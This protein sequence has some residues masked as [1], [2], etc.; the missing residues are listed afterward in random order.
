[1]TTDGAL[2][3][4]TKRPLDGRAPRVQYP[5]LGDRRPGVAP[6]SRRRAPSRSRHRHA[7]HPADGV[8][9]RSIG[10]GARRRH[11]LDLRLP[12]ASPRVAARVWPPG[13]TFPGLR[14]TPRPIRTCGPLRRHLGGDRRRD[15]DPPC[16]PRL[17]PGPVPRLSAP[18]RGVT[19]YRLSR[20][21]GL[22]TDSLLLT[23]C[24]GFAAGVPLAWPVP[25]GCR[26]PPIFSYLL[27]AL[28]PRRG[29]SPARSPLC[30]RSVFSWFLSRALNGLLSG[31]GGPSR[32]DVPRE[33]A[34]LLS[35]ASL[36]RLFGLR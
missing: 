28:T 25:L 3:P 7:R 34:I 19:V 23:A 9:V 13:T 16:V 17:L 21:G 1:M 12:R 31:G 4:G 26:A 32:V 2:A 15:P 10:F 11:R 8:R 6:G 36:L 14:A 20:I 24:G 29:P 18:D 22:R 35:A 5:R 30:D 33:R 27:A